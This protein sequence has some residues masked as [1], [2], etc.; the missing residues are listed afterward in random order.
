MRTNLYKS[1]V[2][3]PAETTRM[4]G[5]TGHGYD[6]YCGWPT[7]SVGGGVLA[8]QPPTS[9]VSGRPSP[10][11]LCLRSVRHHLCTNSFSRP[12]VLA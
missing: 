9:P 12:L 10:G 1:Q 2:T 4:T 6:V 11:R 3:G 5:M 8:S 7:G